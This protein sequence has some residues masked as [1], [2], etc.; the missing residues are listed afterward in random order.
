MNRP[1]MKRPEDILAWIA[2]GA[3]PV[4]GLYWFE[5]Q[6]ASWRARRRTV[7]LGAGG[8]IRRI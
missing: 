2:R 6:S 7:V 5:W 3:V 8:R 1:K 4:D